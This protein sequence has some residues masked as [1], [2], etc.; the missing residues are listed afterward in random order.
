MIFFN[1][2]VAKKIVKSRS[3]FSDPGKVYLHVPYTDPLNVLEGQH[4]QNILGKDRAHQYNQQL[5]QYLI[6]GYRT[7]H[8]S[9]R[10]E[11][12]TFRWVQNL[13]LFDAYR[14]YHFSMPIEPTTFRWVQNL[15]LFDGYRTY[16]FS[17][18]IEPTTFR[19]V[20]NLPLLDVYRTYHFSMPI[21][22]T[23][24][25]WVQNLPLFD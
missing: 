6:D 25:R 19:C 20:Q 4:S 12:T 1:I 15:P 16:H 8:F 17:M 10:I 2:S 5:Y 18:G 21:E 11:P 23:T 13:P 7:Y 24:F 3:S 14:T 9:M 22:P